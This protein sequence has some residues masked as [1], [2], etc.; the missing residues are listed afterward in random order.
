[1]IKR[2][3]FLRKKKT[4]ESIDLKKLISEYSDEK[5]IIALKQRTYYIPEAEKFIIEEAIKR[6]L[7]FSEQDLMAEE[8]KVENLRFSFFPIIMEQNIRE[9]IR[10]SIARSF[11]ISGIIPVVFGL[12]KMNAGASVQGALILLFG[13][14]WIFSASR[15][16][17]GFQK[18]YVWLL[19]AAS[20]LA[21]IYIVIQLVNKQNVDNID[22]FVPAVVFGFIMYGLVFLLKMHE[23]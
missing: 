13:L 1:M 4:K 23:R 14:L 17:R 16:I 3:H 21:I 20:F 5:L 10:K 9:R 19:L 2:H 18:L 12:V 11:V 22:F 6:G 15:L 7:I 8:Y